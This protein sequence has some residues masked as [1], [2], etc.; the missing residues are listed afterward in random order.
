MAY[1]PPVSGIGKTCLGTCVPGV[2][3]GLSRGSFAVLA[4]DNEYMMFD[5]TIVSTY[6]HSAGPL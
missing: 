4:T 1:L 5:H 6:Q 3:A 2:K